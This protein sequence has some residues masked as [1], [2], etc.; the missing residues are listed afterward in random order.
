MYQLNRNEWTSG[1]MDPIARCQRKTRDLLS[2]ISGIEPDN[3]RLIVRHTAVAL[4]YLFLA[5]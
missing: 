5:G 3:A 2:R 4:E 1:Q